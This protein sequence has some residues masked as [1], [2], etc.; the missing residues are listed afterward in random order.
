MKCVN[1]QVQHQNCPIVQSHCKHIRKSQSLSTL[2]Y[3]HL[4]TTSAKLSFSVYLR[5]C[6]ERQQATGQ[7]PIKPAPLCTQAA[8]IHIGKI[9][10]SLTPDLPF[11]P[12]FISAVLCNQSNTLSNAE[13]HQSIRAGLGVF[14]KGHLHFR[15]NRLSLR[16]FS[17]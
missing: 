10:H 5:N 11:F 6:Q 16:V 8:N 17:N 14:F 3:L 12:L 7:S 2:P 15:S 4:N 9:L 1:F 13:V